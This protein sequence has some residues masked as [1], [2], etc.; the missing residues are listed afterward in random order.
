MGMQV[1]LSLL[2][3]PQ[4][5]LLGSAFVAVAIA[6]KLITG[7]V[8]GPGVSKWSIG[9]GMVPRG[10]VGLIFASIGSPARASSTPA[11]STAVVLMVHGL[12]PWVAPLGLSWSLRRAG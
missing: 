2:A 9:L 3:E 7:V 10:E 11:S 1:N 5:L 12:R 6:S 4:T 8:A